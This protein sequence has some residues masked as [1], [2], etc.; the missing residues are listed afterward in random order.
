MADTPRTLYLRGLALSASGMI[1]L[2]PDALLIRLITDAQVWDIIFWRT[3]F[4]GTSLGLALAVRYRARLLEVARGGGWV[5]PVSALLM[6]VSNLSFVGAITHTTVANTLVILAT[7]PL[8]SAVLGWLLIGERVERRTWVAIAVALAGVAVVFSDSLGG[9]LWL[10]D[11]M[12]VA[13][14]ASQGLNLVVLRQ[15]GRRDMTP[16]L[17][18]SGFLAAAVTWPLAEPTAI[19]AHD[20]GILAIL[21]L[22]VLPLSLALFISGTRT[23]PAAEVALLA[24]IETILGPVWAWLGVGET[25]TA[26]TFAGGIA[27]VGAIVA[28]AVL[29]VRRQADS[30]TEGS[31]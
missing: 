14:A 15:A 23:V 30:P 6:A 22:G 18:L 5:L 9:G 21:G 27:V 4:M 11:L 13:T 20:L 29:A 8:F 3:L 25:P 19:T 31:S 7:L 10:G 1:I 28:N 16:A 24:L 26:M 17:C 12:A 2:S